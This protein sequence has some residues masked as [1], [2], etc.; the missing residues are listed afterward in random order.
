RDDEADRRR[1]L[2][3]PEEGAARRRAKELLRR[4]QPAGPEEEAEHVRATRLAE[5]PRRR[6]H[7]ARGAAEQGRQGRRAAAGRRAAQE[8]AG[9]VAVREAGLHAAPQPLSLAK[10]AVA[11]SRS[12]PSP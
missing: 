5:A 4:P 10:A 3:E 11:C 7:P 6:G 1:A 8:R 12:V 2:P 9:R